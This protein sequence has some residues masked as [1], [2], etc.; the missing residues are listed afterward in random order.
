MKLEGPERKIYNKL[1]VNLQA[2]SVFDVYCISKNYVLTDF[3]VVDMF[4][5]V[6]LC[7]ALS[8]SLMLVRFFVS[9]WQ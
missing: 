9:L 1:G 2:D 6:F 7:N 5:Y 3:V 4:W 8:F